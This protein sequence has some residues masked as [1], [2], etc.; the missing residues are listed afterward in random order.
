MRKI[1]HTNI[2]NIVLLLTNIYQ[3]KNIVLLLT[4]FYQLK[5]QVT[6]II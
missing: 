6:I 2:L 5:V 1:K 3:L 4:K